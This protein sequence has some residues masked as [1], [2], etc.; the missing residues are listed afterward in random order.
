MKTT[1]RFSRIAA[2]LIAGFVAAGI[3]AGGAAAFASAPE[4]AAA[5][6]T[7]TQKTSIEQK[8]E[9]ELV[10]LTNKTRARVGLKPLK[11]DYLLTKSTRSWSQ[12]MSSKNSMFHSTTYP[13]PARTE[14]A[15]E[16]VL[17]APVTASAAQ[18]QAAWEASPTHWANL[19]AKRYGYVGFGA[20]ID[21]RGNIWVTA[22]FLGDVNSDYKPQSTPSTKAV[23]GSKVT[24]SKSATPRTAFSKQLTAQKKAVATAKAT[25]K[26]L[27]RKATTSSKVRKA[28]SALKSY[29]SYVAKHTPKVTSKTAVK[30]V[31]KNTATVKAQTT[32]LNK[33]IKAAKKA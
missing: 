24:A 8:V 3:L 25:A 21:D 9:A 14:S 23:A 1:T 10:K 16:N 26:K 19:A 7:Q 33:L 20:E 30:T 18:M 6:M 4:A 32:K 12:V 11:V 17:R 31:Q 13:F 28:V 22:H 15:G 27:A 29:E 5:T 2:K